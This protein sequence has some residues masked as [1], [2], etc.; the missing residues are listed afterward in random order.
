MAH[1]VNTNARLARTALLF[2]FLAACS[3]QP[4]MEIPPIKHYFNENGQAI[5]RPTAS[6]SSDAP[7]FKIPLADA[8]TIGD[9][10][11]GYGIDNSHAYREGYALPDSDPETLQVLSDDYAKDQHH[12]YFKTQIIPQADPKSFRFINLEERDWLPEEGYGIDDNQCYIESVATDC[13][14]LKRKKQF[15]RI[16]DERLRSAETSLSFEQLFENKATAYAQQAALD[17][18]YQL[19]GLKPGSLFYFAAANN[20]SKTIE[21]WRYEGFKADR[22]R[23]TIYLPSKRGRDSIG[24]LDDATLP[25]PI[26]PTNF[27]EMFFNLP[28]LNGNANCRFE[29]INKFQSLDRQHL[30]D[31]M[32]EVEVVNSQEG[33]LKHS[34]QRYPG[35]E[36][37]QI[38]FIRDKYGLPLLVRVRTSNTETIYFRQL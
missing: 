1:Q 11:H 19:N 3:Q 20:P 35:G 31:G 9:L 25:K 14:E 27:A 10:T 8:E 22:H 36:T 30:Y 32:Q 23:F 4:P 18:A 34:V 26:P 38:D 16:K 6:L 33:I 15:S 5:Y 28:C 37:T 24:L 29:T 17:H 21:T 13:G 2:F 7:F 12:V